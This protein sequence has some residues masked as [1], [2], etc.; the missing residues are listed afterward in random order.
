MMESLKE[1]IVKHGLDPKKSLGQNFILDPKILEKI[2]KAAGPLK[3]E[4]VLEIGPG[5]GGLTRAL[6]ENGA[7]VTAVEKDARCIAALKELEVFYPGKLTIL[8]QDA[9]TLN[10]AN[11]LKQK[12]R[13]VANLPY[14]VASQI[15]VHLLREIQNRNSKIRNLTLMFQK[16]VAKRITAKPGEKDYGRLAI[17]SNWLCETKIL[18]DLA[19]GSFFP[20]P[21]V[22]SSLVQLTPKENPFPADFAQMEKLTQKAFGQRRKMV[23]TSLKDYPLKELGID[24]TK[25]PENLTIEEFC[26]LCYLKQHSLHKET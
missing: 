10:Y 14:Y 18:F 13:I 6:L 2:A 17:L 12:T 25:R 11:L 7:N 4:H 22:T 23:K 9:L 20:P 1:T 3:D 15:L 5:P 19:P 8:N 16:E 26:K 24:E 21:K